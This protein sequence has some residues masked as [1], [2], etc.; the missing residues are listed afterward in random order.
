[1]ADDDWFEPHRLAQMARQPKPL[2]RIWAMRK[3]GKQIDCELRFHG[4]SYRWECQCL[5]EGVLAYGPSVK[6]I[7]ARR[8]NTL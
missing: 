8:S 4:E 7:D 1:M 2:E 3:D 5:H 6:N